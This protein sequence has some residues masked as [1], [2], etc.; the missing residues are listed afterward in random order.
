MLDS[1][2]ATAVVFVCSIAAVHNLDTG[3]TERI[4]LDADDNEAQ[5]D[6]IPAGLDFSTSGAFVAFVSE[7]PD[8]VTGDGNGTVDVFVRARCGK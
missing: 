2:R 1:A 6:T 7:S 4:S 3:T 8:L 5:G